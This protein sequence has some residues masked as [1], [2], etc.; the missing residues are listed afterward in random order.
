MCA[1]CATGPAALRSAAWSRRRAGHRGRARDARRAALA[2]RDAVLTG[3]GA[4]QAKAAARAD[5][6]RAHPVCA[7]Y[8]HGRCR[9]AGR[10]RC[11]V[12]RD[13]ADRGRR[14]FAHGDHDVRARCAIGA[15]DSSRDRRVNVDPSQVTVAVLNGTTVQGL[16]AQ[17]AEEAARGGFTP[18][19]TGN[20]ARIDQSESEV[21]YRPGPERARRVPSPTGSAST[22]PGRSTRS[23]RRSPARS[24][25]WCW[26]ARIGNRVA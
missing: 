23:T 9:P 26:S 7:L 2:A 13:A 1:G 16:A 24:T 12:R 25:S 3:S 6:Q 8:R 10:R 20:A 22:R 21:L 11:C 17:V 14:R 19:T 4:A 18:G 5:S 15:G